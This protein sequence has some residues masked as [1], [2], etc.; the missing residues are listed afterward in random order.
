MALLQQYLCLA[1]I[2]C[3]ALKG[4]ADEQNVLQELVNRRDIVQAVRDKLKKINE[5][6]SVT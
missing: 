4:L 1:L 2:F 6:T 3:I 5:G